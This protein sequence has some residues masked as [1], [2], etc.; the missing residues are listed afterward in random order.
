MKTLSELFQKYE[1]ELDERA[2]LD[3]GVVTS[4]RYDKEARIVHT[5]ADFASLIEKNKLRALEAHIAKAYELKS[6]RIFP[7]Y[8]SALFSE[9]YVPEV[10]DEAKYVGAITRGFFC[11]YSASLHDNILNITTSV[12]NGGIELMYKAETN[13]V[14]SDIIRREFG[15]DVTVNIIRNSEYS[16]DFE[17][18]NKERLNAIISQETEYAKQRSQSEETDGDEEEK[19]ELKKVTTLYSGDVTN[20]F[21]GISVYNIGFLKFD[22]GEPTLIYG[23]DFSIEEPIP[24]RGLYKQNIRTVVLGRVVDIA[25]NPSRSGKVSYTI[26]ISDK[27]ASINL[28]LYLSADDATVEDNFKNGMAVAVFGSTRL[29]RMKDGTTG[30]IYF[31]PKSIYKIKL[32]PRVDN[33]AKKR[34]ELH[35]HTNMSAMDAITTPEEAVNTAADWGHPALAITDHGNVQSFPL[36][37]GAA[38][39]RDFKLLYGMEGY[40]VDDTAKAVFGDKNATFDAEF[41]V[42]DIETTGLDA[43][44]CKITEIGAVNVKDGKILEEFNMLINPEMP[45]PKEITEITGISDETVKDAPTIAEVLPQFFEFAKDRILVAHN[46]NFDTGFIRKAAEDLGIDFSNTYL[47]TLSMSKYLVPELGKHKLDTLAKYFKL[48]DFNH[49]RAS[50]DAAMLAQIFFKLT[51]KLRSEGVGDIE[52]MVKTMSEKADPLRLSTYHIV[53][54]AQ[55]KTGLKNLYKIVSASYLDYYRSHPRI[56]KNLLTRYREGIIVGS[57]C[58]AG[59]LF[60]AI[61]DNRPESDIE[62]IAS[63]YDYLEIMPLSNNRFLVDNGKVASEEELRNINRKIVAL[64]KK[65]SKPVVATC[66]AHYMNKEDDIVRRVMLSGMK[67]PDADAESGLYMRTTDEMLEEFSYLG[68]ETAYEVVVENTNKIADMIE[69]IQPIP[70]GTYTPKMEGAEEDLQSMCWARAHDWYGEDLPEIV[71]SRLKRELD[72]IIS[73]GFAVLY[74]IAQKLVSFSEKNGYLVGSRG[75]VGSSFVATMAGISEVNPLPPHYRCPKCRHSEFITDGTVGSGFDLPDKKCPDCGEKMICDGHDIP[76][77]TFL[78]FKGDKS[79]DIDLNFSGDVQAKVH[80]YTEELFGADNV[81]KAGTISTIADKTAY[82]F[83]K[84]YVE[85]K[86]MSVNRAE[87]QRLVNSCVGVKRTT[88]QHP[89]GIIVVPK[90][91]DIYDFT[92]V[93]HPA[94]DPLSD[95][96]TTHFQ[97]SHLHDTILKLDE[98]GHDIPTKYHM[99]EKY[100]NTSV[101][102]VPMNAPEVYKLFEGIDVLGISPSDVGGMTLGTLGLPEFGT[103]FIQQVLTDAKPKNFADLMQISGLTHGTDVW[104]GNAQDLIKAGTCTISEVVG[105]RDGIMLYLIRKGVEK[106]MAFK[107]ME[108][109]RKN[110]KGKPIPDEMVE[111]MREHDVPEWYID[112]CRKIKYM[113]PKAH[114]AAYVMSAIRLGWYKIHYPIEFYAGF[115]TVAPGGFDAATVMKGKGSI[116]ATI[117]EIEKKGNEATAKDADTLFA[118][119][120]ARECVARKIEF[121]PVSLQKSDATAFLPENGKIR[122]PFSSLSGLGATAAQKI[123]D[124][125]NEDSDIFSIEELRQRAGLT[126]AVIEILSENGVLDGMSETNQISMF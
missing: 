63:F 73:N 72:S 85:S 87:I 8:D 50:D 3:M 93:Q 119:Q 116:N 22:V 33:A 20:T 82:G 21:D 84:K 44:S 117:D 28:K 103:R 102:D 106:G 69:K 81:F 104:L 80:K 53:L 74:M 30:D 16:F 56:P 58:E 98:L 14:I 34:V 75:S 121:L 26:A 90:E 92:P 35:F 89:G 43:S 70:D 64:G 10:L 77:E 67:F 51:D 126:K 23:E 96:V 46:A 118:M 65:L 99:L 5:E 91:Y 11:E 31:D 107:I 19:I 111:A 60:R 25:S 47:D 113:F 122:L 125:R 1:A 42:F 62:Q 2:I 86:G 120:L 52:Q 17:E 79:P 45:I 48:G 6:L 95:I 83:V 55:N 101:L 114:A 12:T 59:E 88:G 24:I 61:L 78:G 49:H 97:F 15:I 100:T 7:H 54:L 105:T 38:K 68:E 109:V 57:A 37:M 9:D 112:S 76:F 123:I 36:A 4:T 18:H 124:A 41:C 108:M 115:L 27:D 94:D 29:E 110:K 13:R 40:F 71:E 32:V 66:D 39:A